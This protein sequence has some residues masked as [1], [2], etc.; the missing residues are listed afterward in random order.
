MLF[1]FSPPELFRHLWQL[2]TVVFQHWYLKCAVLLTSKKKRLR[3]PAMYPTLVYTYSMYAESKYKRCGAAKKISA[4]C[5][6]ASSAMFLRR[7]KLF[8]NVIIP[9]V[10][11]L[12]VIFLKLRNNPVHNNPERNNPECNNPECNNP[13]CNNPEC[14][15]PKRNNPKCNNPKCNNPERPFSPPQA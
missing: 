10:I 4:S 11:F 2:K 12:N 9:N 3:P 14:N 15:N 5:E 6:N 1:I 8:P 7:H 13:E